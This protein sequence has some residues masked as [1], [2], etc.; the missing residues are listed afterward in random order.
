VFTPREFGAHWRRL[1]QG[2]LAEADALGAM[3]VKYEDLAGGAL[4]LA[5]IDQY[6]GIATD[7]A[8]MAR[9][10]RGDA[11]ADRAEGK[12]QVNALERWLLRRAV[13]PTAERLGYGW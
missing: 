3:L 5:R 9:K 1:M 7:H 2:Y 8:V 12:A 13:G 6:L 4:P 10:V 11:R